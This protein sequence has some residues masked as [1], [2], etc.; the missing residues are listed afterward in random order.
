MISPATNKLCVF[1]VPLDMTS[2]A[3]GE[4][5]KHIQEDDF[6]YANK[7]ISTYIV[8]HKPIHKTDKIRT[9]TN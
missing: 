5:K 3:I 7:N 6:E 8:M 1:R 2:G 4:I 9:D